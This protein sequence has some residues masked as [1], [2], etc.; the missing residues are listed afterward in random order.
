MVLVC[1]PFLQL[2]NLFFVFAFL[3]G[4]IYHQPS[5]PRTKRGGG[6]SLKRIF[7]VVSPSFLSPPPLLLLAGLMVPSLLFSHRCFGFLEL[8]RAAGCPHGAVLITCDSHLLL[9]G[10]RFVCSGEV[11]E[12]VCASSA[13]TARVCARASVRRWAASPSSFGFSFVLS[14]CHLTKVHFI[15]VAFDSTWLCPPPVSI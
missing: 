14:L 5:W 2:V 10:P 8:L 3:C 1:C 11:S 4:I 7:V 12:Y 13:S 15:G 6:K 9:S